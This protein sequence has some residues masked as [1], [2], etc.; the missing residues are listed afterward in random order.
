[1]DVVVVVVVVSG[2]AKQCE[3]T[4]HYFYLHVLHCT[5]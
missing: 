3:Y 4:I 1:M 2:G 5:F